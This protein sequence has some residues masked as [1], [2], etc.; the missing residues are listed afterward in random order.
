MTDLLSVTARDPSLS[1]AFKYASL[2]LNNSYFLEGLVSPRRE[3]I[4]AQLQSMKLTRRIDLSSFSAL[5]RQSLTCSTAMHQKP[6]QNDTDLLKTK[7]RHMRIV[8]S[9]E[10]SYG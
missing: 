8:W 6:F 5:R 1:L 7:W 9:E 10:V 3:V 4:S 2:L